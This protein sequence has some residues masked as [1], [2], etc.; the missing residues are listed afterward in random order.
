MKP[1]QLQPVGCERF[2]SPLILRPI[3]VGDEFRSAALVL[4]S[5]LPS[6]EL[7]AGSAVYPARTDLDASLATN[8]RPLNRNGK[9]FTDPIDLYLSELAK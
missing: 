9:V 6:S 3:P 8:I 4:S 7:V 2:A 5:D 1:L